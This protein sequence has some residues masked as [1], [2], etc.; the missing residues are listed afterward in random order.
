[1]PISD[2]ILKEPTN[3]WGGP[4]TE[5]KLEAFSKYVSAYLTIM[6]LYPYW[7]TIYFDGFAGSGIRKKQRKSDLYQQLKITPGEDHVYKGSAERV[8][9]L[10]ND[11]SFDFYYFIDT[12]EASLNKLEIKLKN[13]PEVPADK[14]NFKSGDCNHYILELAR[15]LKSNKYAA[16]VLLDPFGMQ[17]KWESIASLKSTRTDIWILVPTGVIVNRLL[18][19]NCEIKQIKKLESFFGLSELE[20]KD[21]FYKK[22]KQTTLFGEEEIINKVTRPIEQIAKIY[23][24]KLK[25]IWTYVT[26]EPLILLNSRS[27]PIFHFIFASNNK[28]ATKIAGQ[29]IKSG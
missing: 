26:E 7:K 5:K 25:T 2:K 23:T 1:M 16:L 17:I 10:K 28:N 24:Q 20:I 13:L 27:V 22:E 11:H 21:I 3:D 12:N 18:D 15:A 14:L 6:K 4:W 29:I 8:L 19:K 9:K